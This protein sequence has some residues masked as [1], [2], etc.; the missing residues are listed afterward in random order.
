MIIPLEPNSVKVLNS[1]QNV[2]RKSRRKKINIDGQVI[3]NDEI[4]SIDRFDG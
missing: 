4:L 3:G 1:E 2:E